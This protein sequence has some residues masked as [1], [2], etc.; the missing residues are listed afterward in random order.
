MR[1]SDLQPVEEEIE[2]SPAEMRAYEMDGLQ[3]EVTPLSPEWAPTIYYDPEKFPN[4]ASM[5]RVERHYA[6][7]YPGRH[8]S[9]SNL[10]I[11]SLQH[12][13]IAK[14]PLVEER[15]RRRGFVSDIEVTSFE[16]GN[17]YP[18]TTYLARNK[19]ATHLQFASIAYLLH[20][21]EEDIKN[22][23]DRSAGLAR[24]IDGYRTRRGKALAWIPA[25]LVERDGVFLAGV[26]LK[27]KERV[28][29]AHGWSMS[30][31]LDHGRRDPFELCHAMPDEI[32]EQVAFERDNS[33]VLFGGASAPAVLLWQTQVLAVLR[34]AVWEIELTTGV[35]FTRQEAA[36]AKARA[37]AL[38]ILLANAGAVSACKVER[39]LAS[40]LKDRQDA[41]RSAMSEENG[42]SRIYGNALGTEQYHHGVTTEQNVIA[43]LHGATYQPEFDWENSWD[44][45][46]PL[47]WLK[48]VAEWIGKLKRHRHA[49]LTKGVAEC[50]TAIFGEADPEDEYDASI[51]DFA[52]VIEDR[53]GEVAWSVIADALPAILDG[54]GAPV[55]VVYDWTRN[56]EEAWAAE[57]REDGTIVIRGPLLDFPVSRVT[58][59][60]EKA[61]II[62]E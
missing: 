48:P 44:R 31:T 17:P 9:Q 39:A 50:L 18:E 12:F 37:K 52:G 62:A 58:Y 54:S 36:E 23:R 55:S 45:R 27:E 28:H 42:T 7:A 38:R 61:L 24:L 16:R 13:A 8:F 59:W 56:P 1:L 10:N 2:F 57:R 20:L 14:Y 21:S 49:I 60:N 41:Y 25:P 29:F 46:D 53:L 43:A 35:A 32:G 5:E 11:E 40:L 4:A 34:K 3:P 22:E 26:K 19:A 33:E 15:F 51:R 6:N 30:L 47:H